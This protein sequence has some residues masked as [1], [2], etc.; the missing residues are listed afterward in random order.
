[1]KSQCNSNDLCEIPAGLDVTLDESMDVGALLV[2]GALRWSASAPAGTE[3]SLL[4][5]LSLFSSLSAL[6]LSHSL[7][8]SLSFS[9][10]SYPL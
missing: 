7:S 5:S 4:L 10:R 8:H 6:S 2:K 9:P 3:V 1:M